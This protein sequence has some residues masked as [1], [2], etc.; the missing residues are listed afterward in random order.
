MQVEKQIYEII[1]LTVC[2]PFHLLNPLLFVTKFYIGLNLM[3][4]EDT[5]PLYILIS[6]NH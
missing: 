5:S 3:T 6:H 1:I 2:S 4:L